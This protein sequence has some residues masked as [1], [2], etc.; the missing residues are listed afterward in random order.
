MTKDMNVIKRGKSNRIIISLSVKNF[1]SV[2]IIDI[3]FPKI[4]I[5]L[6]SLAKK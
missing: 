4:K 6:P 3:I 1:L 5:T 2:K